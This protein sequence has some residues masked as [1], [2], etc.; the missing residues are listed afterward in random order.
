MLLENVFEIIPLLMPKTVVNQFMF[1][2]GHEQCIAT[3][4]Q[5][6]CSIITT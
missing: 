2:W 3:M 4:G 5:L 6:T 1:L